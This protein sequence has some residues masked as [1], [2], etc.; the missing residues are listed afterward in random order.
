[1]DLFKS[2]NN[3]RYNDTFKSR[4]I[5]N[6]SMENTENRRLNQ[7][8][9]IQSSKMSDNIINHDIFENGRES[10]MTTTNRDIK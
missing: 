8:N 1:M 6:Q 9:C 7:V 10:Y 3:S 4:D 5:L 2:H